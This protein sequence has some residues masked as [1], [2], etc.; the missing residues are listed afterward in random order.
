[1]TVCTD[2]ISQD[3]V[4]PPVDWQNDVYKGSRMVAF[5][6]EFMLITGV[7]PDAP[8]W[9]FCCMTEP[10]RWIFRHSC[11]ETTHGRQMD[12]RKNARIAENLKVKK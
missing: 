7:K 9:S 8:E 10:E 5:G 6:V 1:V 12:L 11:E 2:Q 3:R 4:Q